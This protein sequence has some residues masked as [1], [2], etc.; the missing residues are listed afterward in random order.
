MKKLSQI[1]PA[2]LLPAMMLPAVLITGTLALSTSAHANWIPACPGGFNLDSK[3]GN[4]RA[5]SC[6]RTLRASCA[7]GR[8]PRVNHTGTDTCNGP[9]V[10]RNPTGCKLGVGRSQNNW[11]IRRDRQGTRDMCIH[12]TR[13]VPDKPI[14]C[15]SGFSQR[16]A[17][18][19]D[20]CVKTSGNRVPSTCPNGSV[21]GE[22]AGQ[23]ACI[24]ERQPS[25]RN[26]P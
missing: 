23:D 4:P 14:K 21:R 22:R 18:G 25:W 9:D 3:N 2:V 26:V 20:R 10:V 8:A 11:E 5:Y 6:K 16:P 24:V 15:Q 13:N 17:P 1:L 7:D 19:A 12:K